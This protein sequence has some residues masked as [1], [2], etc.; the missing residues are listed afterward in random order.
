VHRDFDDWI[1]HRTTYTLNLKLHQHF[2]A[3]L[4]RVMNRIE[5]W[6]WFRWF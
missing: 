3:S 1:F 5:S 2:G 4:T 6:H